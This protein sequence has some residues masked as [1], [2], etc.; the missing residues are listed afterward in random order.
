M[1]PGTDV[2]RDRSLV[3]DQ[4]LRRET[5]TGHPSLLM[6]SVNLKPKDKNLVVD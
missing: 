2:G 1:I 3:I 4:E 5:T 6:R